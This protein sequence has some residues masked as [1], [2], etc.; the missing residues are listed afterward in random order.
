VDFVIIEQLLIRYSA[1]VRHRR[2]NG[3]KVGQVFIDFKQTYDS[4]EKYYAFGRF[5]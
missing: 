4:E 3:G 5:V 2:E 1:F